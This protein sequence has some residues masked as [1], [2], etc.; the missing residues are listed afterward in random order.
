MRFATLR[1]LWFVSPI[2]A[3]RGC[4]RYG[5]DPDVDTLPIRVRVEAD[6]RTSAAVGGLRTCGMWHC[7]VCG[8]KIAGVRSAELEHMFRL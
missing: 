8:T 1:A 5:A 4:R 3:E 2:K 7:P 6:G